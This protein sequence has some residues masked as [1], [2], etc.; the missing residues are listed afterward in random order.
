MARNKQ[1]PKHL[2]V[3]R[4]SAMGDVAMLPHA[5]RALSAAYPDL[6]I[7]VATQAMF[8]PFFR[9]LDVEFL[10]VRTKDEHHSLC[11]MWRL[12]REARQ[13]GVDA[14]ADVHNVLRS[15]AFRLAMSLH[16]IRTATICKGRREKRRALGSGGAFVPLKHSV[17]RYCDVIRRLGFQFE[18]PQPAEKPAYENP[19]GEKSGRWIGYAPF[20]AH[21]GKTYPEAQSRALVA[22]LAARYDR[23]F[24]HGGGG[25]EQ[26]FAEE[27]ERAYPN[28]TATF[29]KLRFAG[30]MELMAHQDCLISMDSMA[31]HMASLVA[32]PVVSVWGAT[33]PK[34]G[35]LGWGSSFDRAL[36]AEMECRPCSVFGAK[37]CQYGD[38]RCLK[39]VTPEMIVEKIDQ[40]LTQNA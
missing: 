8:R 2:L 26:A 25:A 36:Q 3:F 4:T 18:D 1:L 33:H 16:G 10:E 35:F 5:L 37:P 27:M 14:V 17:V 32:T 38:Y 12:A 29:G 9:G 23:V 15:K 30:E 21:A 24:I 31:M 13:R 39:A 6:K 7:T 28:V 40:I 19:M 20:S 22:L 34:L 11:G